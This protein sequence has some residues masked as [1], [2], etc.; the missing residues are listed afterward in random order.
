MPTPISAIFL[1]LGL[2][3]SLCQAKEPNWQE[4]NAILA[5]HV[6]AGSK[7]DIIL[8][9]VDY[10]ALSGDTR[11]QR[12]ADN[13]GTFATQQLLTENEEKAFYINA[14][15]I[16]TLKL[17]A[18]NWPVESIKDLGIWPFTIWKKKIAMLDG[19]AASLHYIEHSVLRSFDD[20][21]IHFAINCASTGCPE[22]RREAYT[23]AKLDQQL[24]EQSQRFL[25]DNKG[26]RITED[27]IYVSMIFK[28]YKKD[29]PNGDIKDFIQQYQPP[30]SQYPI[31]DYFSYDWTVN[32]STE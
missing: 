30:L 22:L 8:N 10:A 4:Y 2:T 17:I 11:L 7:N 9:L 28:W 24:N 25:I 3:V 1:L 18:D 21:R 13:I 23:A 31:I 27:G 6:K 15:N 14:Y 26:I 12:L 29:F 20:P 32:A 19:K 16:F 5:D